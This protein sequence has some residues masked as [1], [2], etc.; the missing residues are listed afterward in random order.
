MEG[1]VEDGDVFDSSSGY[2]V[3]LEP[4]KLVKGF[5]LGLLTC[6]V[7]ERALSYD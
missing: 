2:G 7:G 5:S 1:R 6:A 3:W 4:D